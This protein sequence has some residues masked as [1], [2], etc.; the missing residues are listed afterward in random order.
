MPIDITE[1]ATPKWT[2][3]QERYPLSY[4]K[5]DRFCEVNVKDFAGRFQGSEGRFG[6]WKQAGYNPNHQSSQVEKI[7]ISSDNITLK[8]Y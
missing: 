2:R 5:E 4:N 8:P 7:R 3:Q 6:G 1:Y